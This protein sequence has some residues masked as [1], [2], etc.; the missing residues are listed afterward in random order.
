MKSLFYFNPSRH[1]FYL[2]PFEHAKSE[3]TH[4]HTRTRTHTHMVN[5]RHNQ[6][7]GSRTTSL[8]APHGPPSFTLT[9]SLSLS[10]SQTLTGFLCCTASKLFALI[11]QMRTWFHYR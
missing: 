1:F 10:P 4:T 9:H 3:H 11:M 7:R 5:H 8:A 2:N 6:K